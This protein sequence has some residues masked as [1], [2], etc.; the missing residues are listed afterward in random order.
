MNIA[1][2]LTGRVKMLF[3]RLTMWKIIVISTTLLCVACF[4]FFPSL[5]RLYVFLRF[6]ASVTFSRALLLVSCFPALCYQ[7]NVFPRSVSSLL[8]S[9]ALLQ[10]SFSPRFVTSVFPRF[11]ASVIFSSLCCKFHVFPRFVASVIF[12]ALCCKCH[13][14]SCFVTCV[15]FFRAL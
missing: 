11:V 7:F 5:Y 15:M 10:V 1:V 6:V 8:F 4:V 2:L 13:V 3:L 9:R 12:P 14:L